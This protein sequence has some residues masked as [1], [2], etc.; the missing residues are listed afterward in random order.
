MHFLVVAEP[1]GWGGTEANTTLMIDA[2]GGRGH[3]VDLWQIPSS[4]SGHYSR[5]WSNAHGELLELSA[6]AARGPGARTWW[7]TRLERLAPAVVVLEKGYVNTLFPGLDL[8]ARR[9]RLPLVI[10]EHHPAITPAELTRLRPWTY[11]REWASPTYRALQRQ[12]RL[13]S[14]RISVSHIT[15]RALNAYLRWTPR[16]STVIHPGIRFDQFVPDPAGRRAARARHGIPEAALVFGAV[17]RL[18]PYKR[19]DVA[20]RLLASSSRLREA[21]LLLAGEGSERE[22]LEGLAAEL[23]VADRVRFAGWI[24]DE[25][26][27]VVL[28]AL[29]CFVMLS[30]LEGL[31]MALIEAIA[32]G[33]VCI[34][35]ECGGPQEIL[36]HPSLGSLIP[37]GDWPAATAAMEE[38][39]DRHRAGTLHAAAGQRRSLVRAEYDAEVQNSRYAD[40]LEAVAGRRGRAA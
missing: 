27:R 8:A 24:P 34:A 4:G 37:Q 5:M 18:H 3:R 21:Y 19:F 6:D 17:G 32:C 40:Y 1:N 11:L 35:T 31:G 14:S 30:D 38:V 33:C 16:P 39:G 10:I 2:L 26:R 22:R 25:E 15:E 12:H 9:C 13:A 23:G 36:T 20:L 28:S 7:N 29:D